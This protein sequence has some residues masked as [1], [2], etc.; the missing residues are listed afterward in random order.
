MQ[1]AFN[2]VKSIIFGENNTSHSKINMPTSERKGPGGLFDGING[3]HKLS[4]K[5]EPKFKAQLQAKV[6]LGT[7]QRLSFGTLKDRQSSIKSARKPESNVNKDHNV[8][9]SK[10]VE[11]S[12]QNVSTNLATE[13]LNNT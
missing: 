2:E 10:L 4:P 11:L 8:T 13:L 9:F 6:E 1:K 3:R 12:E 5:I 7:T